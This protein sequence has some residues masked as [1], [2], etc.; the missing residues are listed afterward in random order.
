MPATLV[1]FAEGVIGLRIVYAVDE[2][3]RVRD[4]VVAAIALAADGRAL[5]P[6]QVEDLR[7][8]IPRQIET[9]W[10]HAPGAPRICEGFVGWRPAFRSAF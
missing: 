9:G 4:A 2:S 7:E 1:N 6:R 3:G 10:R 5:T 8:D